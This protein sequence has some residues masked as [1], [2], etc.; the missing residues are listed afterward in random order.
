MAIGV[1]IP[2]VLPSLAGIA[3][4]ALCVGGTVMV[5]TMTGIQGLGVWPVQTPAR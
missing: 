3:I 1:L 5:N 4:A 2:I